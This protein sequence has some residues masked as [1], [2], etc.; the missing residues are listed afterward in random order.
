M[1][2][3]VVFTSLRKAI[4]FGLTYG[5]D[6]IDSYLAIIK[7][8]HAE[9]KTLSQ[10]QQKER[11]ISPYLTPTIR[12]LGVKRW[13][14]HQHEEKFFKTIDN[15]TYYSCLRANEGL[16]ELLR[17]LYGAIQIVIGTL[18]ARRQ[19]ELTDLI[20]TKC[21]IKTNVT[22]YFLLRKSGYDGKREKIARPIPKVAVTF[23]QLLERLQITLKKQECLMSIILCFLIH[24][25]TEEDWW[26]FVKYHLTNR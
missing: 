22:W 17:V 19:R 7:A 14:I 25:H 26:L 13:L 5:E 3:C 6:L 21:I 20:A 12:A 2:S 23:I 4:E 11:D 15:A 9:N 24:Q 10:W 16:W 18:M 8:S 1:P